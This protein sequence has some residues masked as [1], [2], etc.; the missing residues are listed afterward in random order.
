M[1]EVFH[2]QTEDGGMK[3]PVIT[4]L[5]FKGGVILASR[6][7]SYA[8]VLKFE[9]LKVVVKELMREQHGSFLKAVKSGQYDDKG[10]GEAPE[11]EEAVVAPAEAREMAAAPTAAPAAAPAAEGRSIDDIVLERLSLKMEA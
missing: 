8:D 9:N 11:E 3:N 5:L 6:K 10:E 1:G 4:T 7:T 2:V